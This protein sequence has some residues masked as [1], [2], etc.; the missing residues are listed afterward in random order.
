MDQNNKK[1]IIAG[2]CA[3]ESKEQLHNTVKSIYKYSNVIRAGIWKAR[4][5]PTNYS[6]IGSKGLPWIKTLQNKYK[7]PI[8][9]EI[10]I[11]KHVELALKHDIRIFW[12]GA[13]TTSNP[14]AIQELAESTRDKHI[15]IWIK[16]PII[17]DIKLWAGAIERFSQCGIHKLKIIHRGFY[18]EKKMRYR[19]DPHWKLLENFKK[20][21][22]NIPIICDPSHIAGNTKYIY[23]IA[24]KACEK[25]IDGLMFEVHH[26]PSQ[27][28]SDKKQQLDPDEFLQLLKKL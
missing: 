5:L 12:I 1:L 3:V 19:N 4:T 23:R 25:N 20:S 21:Y 18:S 26:K 6:G 11:P 16:N 15:E 7:I 17:S 9:I 8:A 10:G 13:R 2:P 24:K 27:A 14:F 22:P 28:L